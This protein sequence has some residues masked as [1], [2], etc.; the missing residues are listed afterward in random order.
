MLHVAI[1]CWS[2]G[3]VGCM[4]HVAMYVVMLDICYDV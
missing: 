3:D 1:G 2:I 4:L